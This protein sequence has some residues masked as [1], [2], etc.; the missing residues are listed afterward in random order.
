MLM[1]VGGV[2]FFYLSLGFVCVFNVAVYN[3]GDRFVAMWIAADKS[4]NGLFK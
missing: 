4:L 2:G 1:E 3:I